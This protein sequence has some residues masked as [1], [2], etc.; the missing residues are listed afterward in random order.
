MWSQNKEYL[1]SDEVI[2][3]LIFNNFHGNN[4]MLKPPSNLLKCIIKE[5]NDH[6][7]LFNPFSW[8]L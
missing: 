1:L 5:G 6:Q 2:Y 8:I 4:Y 3:S 7:T